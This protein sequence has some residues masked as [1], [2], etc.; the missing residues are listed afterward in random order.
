MRFE[1]AMPSQHIGHIEG[2]L[3][4]IIERQVGEHVYRT[5]QFA[6]GKLKAGCNHSGRTVETCWNGVAY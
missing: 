6:I 5:D 4:G 1:R 2:L 3:T